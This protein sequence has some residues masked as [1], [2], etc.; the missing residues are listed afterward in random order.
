MHATFRLLACLL[1]ALACR[2]HS[3]RAPGPGPTPPASGTSQ[4]MDAGAAALAR[5]VN[6]LADEYLKGWLAAFPEQGTVLGV[7]GARHDRLSDRSASAERAWQAQ[8]DQWL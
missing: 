8:E 6:E 5:R 4:R 3:A 1:A 2:P 7:P